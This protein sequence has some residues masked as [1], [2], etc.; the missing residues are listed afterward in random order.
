[1]CCHTHGCQLT[2]NTVRLF[3]CPDREAVPSGPSVCLRHQ[4]ARRALGDRRQHG[5]EGV[6]MLCLWSGHMMVPSLSDVLL[7]YFSC[8]LWAGWG[9]RGEQAGQFHAKNDLIVPGSRG[10][11]NRL[12]SMSKHLAAVALCFFFRW[13]FE[14]TTEVDHSNGLLSPQAGGF[15]GLKSTYVFL[16]ALIFW[17]NS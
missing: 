15:F 5:M 4:A 17:A 7:L 10:V 3:V 11:G 13:S 6:P 1:M 2:S 16:A 12:W 8:S 9:I 14:C